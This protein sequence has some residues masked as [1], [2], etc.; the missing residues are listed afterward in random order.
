MEQGKF[1]EAEEE[2]KAARELAEQFEGQDPRLTQSITNLAILHNA[3]G[4]PEQAEALLQQA[5]AIHE[6]IRILR[7]PN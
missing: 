2:L 4:E 5:V 6:K 1:P 7:R 3:K